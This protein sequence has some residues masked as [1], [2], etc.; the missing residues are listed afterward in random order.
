MRPYILTDRPL[1]IYIGKYDNF[2]ACSMHGSHKGNLK[3]DVG[4]WDD[5]IKIIREQL[6]PA[7]SVA[8]SSKQ[9]NE[10]SGSIKAG[11]YFT[12]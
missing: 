8:N 1:E 5:N 12:T 9:G 10:P 2:G 7:G 6:D 3:V 4:L 11:H